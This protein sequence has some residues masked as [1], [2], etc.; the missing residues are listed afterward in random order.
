MRADRKILFLYGG[1]TRQLPEP[2]PVHRS[3]NPAPVNLNN[4]LP[5]KQIISDW[6]YKNDVMIQI[7]ARQ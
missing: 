7:Y 4:N 1:S 3:S 2:R 6:R 5:P